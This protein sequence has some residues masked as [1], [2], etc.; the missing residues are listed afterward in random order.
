MQLLD[1]EEEEQEGGE[2]LAV[3]L[4]QQL[5]VQQH[6]CKHQ[7]QEATEKTKQAESENLKLLKEVVK[8]KK[9][10]GQKQQDVEWLRQQMTDI[11][12]VV[13]AKQVRI[14]N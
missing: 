11:N 13:A 9:V 8:M 7:V 3:R 1:M 4:R 14:A 6:S 12:E 5:L 10:L 2:M